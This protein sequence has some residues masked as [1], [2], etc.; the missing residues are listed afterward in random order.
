MIAPL[1]FEEYLSPGTEHNRT[2]AK[3]A[4]TE[5]IDDASTSR[6]A[7]VENDVYK[8]PTTPSHIPEKKAFVIH[9]EPLRR[10]IMKYYTC[11]KNAARNANPLSTT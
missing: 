9:L 2:I 11:I 7:I 3:K 4:S 1:L 10:A 8:L 6:H 5:G